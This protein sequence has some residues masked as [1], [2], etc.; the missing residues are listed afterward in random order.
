MG[1]HKDIIEEAKKAMLAKE[2]VR[3][4]VLKDIK[5]AFMNALL[6]KKGPV[7]EELPDTEAFLI[8]RRLVNQRKDSI[9]QFQKGGRID[10]VKKEQAELKVLENYLPPLMNESEIKKVVEKKAK[11]FKGDKTKIG[12]LMAEIMKDLKG[13]ADGAIV[14]KVV[15]QMFQ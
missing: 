6:A 14:K 8:L 2:S 4:D 5:A 11:K 1:I 9:E 7:E 12:Q 15:D 10:L 3:L 13:K